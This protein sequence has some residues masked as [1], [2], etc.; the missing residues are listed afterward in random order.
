MEI[1]S[2]SLIIYKGTLSSLNPMIRHGRFYFF[3]SKGYVEAS[4]YYVDDV[5]RGTWV[6]YNEAMDTVRSID[7]G[8]IWLYM[9]TE[10]NDYTIDSTVF[11]ELNRNDK[12]TMNADGAFYLVDHM[13]EFEGDNTIEHFDNYIQEHLYYPI[14]AARKGITG[15]V[16]IQFMV[17]TEGKVRNPQIVQRATS[18]LNI[19]ALRVLL[20]APDWKPGS[21]AGHP[22]NVL[23]SW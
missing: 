6:Y 14:Y 20:E 7:Y 23:F 9:E 8:S 19:E 18:D 2:D 10:A 21:Q 22:A 11:T 3:N 17:D 12:E 5:P 13:P 15:N 16:I 4:G 1:T